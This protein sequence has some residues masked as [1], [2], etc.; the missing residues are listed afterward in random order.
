MFISVY[1]HIFIIAYGVEKLRSRI[2]LGT[3]AE[4]LSRLKTEAR[5]QAAS[6]L[7]VCLYE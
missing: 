1:I 5:Q 4:G 3:S 2:E 6:F 7:S